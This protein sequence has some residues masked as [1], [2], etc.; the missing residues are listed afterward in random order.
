LRSFS[1]Y[2]RRRGPPD[3]SNARHTLVW[4]VSNFHSRGSSDFFPFLK[5]QV[6]CR[7]REDSSQ[8]FPLYLLGSHHGSHCAPVTNRLRAAIIL[9]FPPFKAR[10]GLRREVTSCLA[11]FAPGTNWFS[12]PSPLSSQNPFSLRAKFSLWSFLRLLLDFLLTHL[13]EVFPPHPTL[14]LFP[15]CFREIGGC[16]PLSPL[17][18][19]SSLVGGF[20]SC[21]CRPRLNCNEN[22]R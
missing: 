6:I 9:V 22:G 2:A 4:A 10:D 7:G 11:R 13:S 18:Q 15:G 19:R 8:R 3:V 14:Y 12:S 21:P 5:D 1:L 16:H 20:K 17:C